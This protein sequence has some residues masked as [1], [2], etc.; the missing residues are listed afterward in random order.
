MEPILEISELEAREEKARSDRAGKAELTDQRE[1][2]IPDTLSPEERENHRYGDYT[3]LVSPERALAV[4]FEVLPPMPDFTDHERN[5]FVAT[6]LEYAKQWGKVANQLPGRNYK[7]VI[8]YY[9]LVKHE[10]KLKGK[11]KRGLKGRRKKKAKT[12]VHTVALGRDDDPEDPPPV[13]DE[14]GTRRRPRRAA[15]PTF[16]GN[17]QPET[18]TPSD[19]EGPTPA[20]TS[21]RGAGTPK[22]EA[23]G[24]TPASKC[25]A[26]KQATEKAAKQSKNT[27]LIAAATRNAQK[28]R[29]ETKGPAPIPLKMQDRGLLRQGPPEPEQIANQQHLPLGAFDSSPVGRPQ[30]PPCQTPPTSMVDRLP[31]QLASYEVPNYRA[32]KHLGTLEI[33][34]MLGI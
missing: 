26:K 29:E 24:D 23:N 3:N 30:R 9:Y 16:G 5:V 4:F 6:M 2:V 22:G 19:S 20:P 27:Q 7:H 10:L 28:N 13:I 21:R 8:Q 12:S 18:A 11:P 17:K 32:H 1:A 31:P 15:A 25:R 14:G 34:R 33:L